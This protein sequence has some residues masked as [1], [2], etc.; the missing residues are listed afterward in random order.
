MGGDVSLIIV[1]LT[2]CKLLAVPLCSF[3]CGRQERWWAVHPMF[4]AE[5]TLL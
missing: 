4:V 3:V 2:A 5:R 1:V